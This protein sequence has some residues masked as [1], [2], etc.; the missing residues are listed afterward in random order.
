MSKSA[1]DFWSRRRAAVEAEAR[2]EETAAEA[3]VQAEAE[4]I[5]AKR[6]DEEI[7]AEAG[8]PAPEDVTS[9]EQVREF[10]QSTLPQ[11][12]KTRALR[13]LWRMNPVLANIDGLVDYGE[14]FTDAAMCVDNMQTVYQVG[15]GMVA[16]L[17]EMGEALDADDAPT[18]PEVVADVA[19]DDA[20]EQIPEAATDRPE[21][22]D[23]AVTAMADPDPV[24]A[25]PTPAPEDDFA[26][27]PA[28]GRRMRFS[29]ATGE[30]T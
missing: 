1:N 29:F 24:A 20:Q 27:L 25:V 14:D 18:A 23:E 13:S 16:K 11:R 12:L 26:P 9:P 2:A 17:E 6:P 21:V 5:Q 28:P 3:A 8:L 4:A 30:A 19:S 10:L 22:E 15:R 7:L